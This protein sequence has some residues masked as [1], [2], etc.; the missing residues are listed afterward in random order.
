MANQGGINVVVMGS[1]YLIGDILSYHAQ[2]DGLDLWEELSI[3]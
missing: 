2:H 1:I 3:H